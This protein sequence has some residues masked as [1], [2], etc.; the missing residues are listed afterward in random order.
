ML[1]NF[2]FSI[3]KKLTLMEVLIF[4]CLVSEGLDIL[5]SINLHHRSKVLPDW[6]IYTDLPEKMLLILLEALRMFLNVL[7]LW[8]S[9]LSKKQE[10][11]SSW[12]GLRA[13]LILSRKLS[14]ERQSQQFLQ[15][16]Y[17]TILISYFT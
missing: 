13:K 7:S 2:V 17:M 12:L 6:S 4:S 14:K 3:K 8:E 11:L 10:K 1:P 9:T 5:D 15:H 16:F